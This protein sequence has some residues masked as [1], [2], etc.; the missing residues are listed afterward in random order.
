MKLYKKVHSKKI[1]NKSSFNDS[2]VMFLS[3]FGVQEISQKFHEV[4]SPFSFICSK[5]KP[6]DFNFIPSVL[7][8]QLLDDFIQ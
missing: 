2:L 5:D 1:K 6:R 3:F 8:S 4:S 7:A